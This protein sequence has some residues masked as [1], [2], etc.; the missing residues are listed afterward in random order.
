M[1]QFLFSVLI[2]LFFAMVMTINVVQ[3]AGVAL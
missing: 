1:G 2:F 3:A